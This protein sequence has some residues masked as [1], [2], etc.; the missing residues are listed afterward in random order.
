MDIG[1]AP[2]RLQLSRAKGWRI[3]DYSANYVIVDR[4]GIW[5]NH[6]TILQSGKQWLVLRDNVW[7]VLAT[8][9]T[10]TEAAA[11]AVDRYRQWLTDDD[12]AIAHP[13][14]MWERTWVLEHLHKLRG[15]TLCC[16]CKDDE[17]C[18]ARVLDEL[19]NGGTP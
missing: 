7:P 11:F 18:H 2:K 4:R 12:F 6:W 19:A 17:P 15:K 3:A 14:L 5:G 13:G 16:W 10:K 8:F 9:D 1:T